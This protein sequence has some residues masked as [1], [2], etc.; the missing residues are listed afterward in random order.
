MLPEG[1]KLNGKTSLGVSLGALSAALG[2]GGKLY[3]DRLQV[4]REL[5]GLATEVRQLRIDLTSG[6]YTRM[7]P[8]TR[9]ALVAVDQ[10]LERIEQR[11]GR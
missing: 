10:R 9:A 1:A 4:E 5:A 2:I 6:V 8:E 7:A 11:L 3:A